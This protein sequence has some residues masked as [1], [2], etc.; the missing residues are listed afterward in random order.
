MESRIQE[1]EGGE[2]SAI[3]NT[4]ERRKGN[5]EFMFSSSIYQILRQCD[6][7]DKQ[8]CAHHETYRVVPFR[9]SVFIQVFLQPKVPTMCFSPS[10]GT[11]NIRGKGGVALV[12]NSLEKQHMHVTCESCKHA[13][14][15]AL[16]GRRNSRY[17]P[18]TLSSDCSFRYTVYVC[19]TLLIFF[20]PS[21]SF[22]LNS[23]YQISP[24]NSSISTKIC[25]RLNSRVGRFAKSAPICEVTGLALLL[26]L[27]LLCRTSP[28]G[29]GCCPSTEFGNFG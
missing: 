10:R 21:I 19:R 18:S 8:A 12:K 26:S 4:R 2:T 1:K 17:M 7:H 23:T 3:M 22:H 11:T 28:A 14:I 15:T 27:L 6:K 16:L 25:F 13:E 24:R 20:L 29:A 9:V 5:H